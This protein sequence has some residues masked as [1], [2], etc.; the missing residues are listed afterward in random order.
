MPLP[1]AVVG[2][3]RVKAGPAPKPQALLPA[4]CFCKQLTDELAQLEQ[5]MCQ[6]ALRVM[7]EPPASAEH[8]VALVELEGLASART[9][10][11]CEMQ[12][13]AAVAAIA[14]VAAGVLPAPVPP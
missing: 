7:R 5:D 9:G 8:A 4:L 6:Q 14:L 13:A 2:T 10:L 12:A 3:H 11:L 1:A